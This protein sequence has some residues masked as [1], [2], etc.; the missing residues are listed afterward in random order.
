MIDSSWTAPRVGTVRPRTSRASQ[1]VTLVAVV[2]PPLGVLAAMGV[3]WDVGFGWVDL[4]LLVGLYVLCAFGITVGFHRY[5]T[6]RGFEATAAV[7]ATLAILGCM[8]MQGPLTRTP[9]QRIDP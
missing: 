8:T 2:V 6:H 5:F 3:L 1:V 4:A 9:K 7:K